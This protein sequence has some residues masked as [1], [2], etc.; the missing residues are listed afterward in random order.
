M[1]VAH[2]FSVDV[3]EYFQV[4]AFEP[5]VHRADWNDQPS[6]VRA[7]VRLLLDLLLKH[8]SRGTFF[9]LGW[10]ADRHPDLVRDIAAAG[11]EVASHGW[12]HVRVTRQR[13]EE[14][15]AS[16]RRTKHELE[17]LTGAEVLGFRAPSFSIVPGFEWALDVLIE[18]GY[19]Y[20]SSMFP[21]RRPGDY[22]YPDAAPE[23]HWLERPAGRL[24]EFPLATLRRFGLSIPAAGGAYF[25]VLPYGLVRAALNDCAH[26]NVPAT[27][28]IH[29]WELDPGQ[30]RLAVPW[31]TRV[32][33]YTG[34]ERTQQ[35]LERLLAEFRFTAI[36][37]S[38]AAL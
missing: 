12:D 24:A 21:I 5:V 29:P 6:R 19:R 36:A 1:G 28:Y 16:V 10:L 23:P 27:F 25:R 11:H 14:F 13:P 4:S 31:L 33:H 35:R 18:E 7:S 26:R 3:E 32:R 20:D 30:P 9:V 22:G 38:L 17:R 34:L 8:G 37:D 2:H 15:R